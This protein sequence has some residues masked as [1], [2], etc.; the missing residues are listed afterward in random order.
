LRLRLLG[1]LTTHSAL[2]R[3]QDL[4]PTGKFN[5]EWDGW[6]WQ[7][8]QGGKPV[9]Y[10]ACCTSKGFAPACTCAPRTDC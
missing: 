1:C 4:D 9:P 6:K 8:T 7:A 5:S 10:S 3:S 2:S